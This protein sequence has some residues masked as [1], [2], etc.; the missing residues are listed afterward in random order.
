MANTDRKHLNDFIATQNMWAGS[1]LN[2]SKGQTYDSRNLS[3]QDRRE[4]MHKLDS[5]LSPENLTCDG[6]LTGKT[7]Q[8]KTAYLKGAKKAL[9]AMR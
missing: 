5:A 9:E 2:K 1:T 7:L 4:L 3:A 8:L 6:E